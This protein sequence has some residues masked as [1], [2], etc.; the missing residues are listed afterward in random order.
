MIVKPKDRRIFQELVDALGVAAQQ[1]LPIGELAVEVGRFFLGTPYAAGTLERRGREAL[2]VN[3]REFDCFTFVENAAV[4]AR[5]IGSGK[6]GFADY[7][8]ALETLR[9]RGGRLNGYASR[10]HYFSDW[11]REN[12]KKRILKDVTREIGGR[13]FPKKINFMTR[14]PALYPAL[15]HPEIFR[16]M[17]A[18]QRICARR[19][20]FHLPRRELRAA[21]EGIRDG[22]LIGITTEREGLDVVHAGLAVRVKNRLHLLHASRAAGK[23]VISSE[24]LSRYLAADESRAGIMVGRLRR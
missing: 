11:L 17:L 12:Q 24:T 22:D 16:E 7:A 3:L 9:Y 18:V 15:K 6:E 20:L 13:V 21:E 5:L 14:N 19:R 2:L 4:L 8:V 1:K 10:L 23:V